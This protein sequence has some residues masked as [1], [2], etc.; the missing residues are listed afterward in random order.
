MEDFPF[1]MHMI[2]SLGVGDV[3]IREQGHIG[4]RFKRASK[5]P[6]PGTKK[7]Q[8]SLVNLKMV[9]QAFY[10]ENKKERLYKEVRYHINRGT[11]RL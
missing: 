10:W 11:R 9:E 5:N 4:L 2:K 3:A 6:P 1:P 8:K 7:K